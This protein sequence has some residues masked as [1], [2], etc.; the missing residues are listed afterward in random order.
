MQPAQNLVNIVSASIATAFCEQNQLTGIPQARPTL[1]TAIPDKAPA[2]TGIDLTNMYSW[3][4]LVDGDPLPPF[5]K[6]FHDTHTNSSRTY[7]LD[8]FLKE[9]QRSNLHIQYTI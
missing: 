6:A 3:C 7:V 9:V 8:V 1:D 4:S 2:M 5:W